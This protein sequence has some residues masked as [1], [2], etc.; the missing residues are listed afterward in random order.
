MGCGTSSAATSTGRSQGSQSSAVESPTPEAQ[1]EEYAV[2]IL[3][4]TPDLKAPLAAF[5]GSLPRYKSELACLAYLDSLEAV[6]EDLQRAITGKVAAVDPTSAAGPF[7]SALWGMVNKCLSE[8][9]GLNGPAAA[10]ELRQA[11]NSLR[12]ASEEVRQ[13]GQAYTV[14][15]APESA[16]YWERSCP[17]DPTAA[18][19]HIRAS[20]RIAVRMLAVFALKPFACSAQGRQ[21][22]AAL[23][24]S[25]YIEP[26]DAQPTR[27][28]RICPGDTL[29]DILDGIAES[30]ETTPGD[31]ERSKARWL[32]R[33]ISQVEDLPISVTVGDAG[34]LSACRRI[35]CACWLGC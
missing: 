5:L 10:L 30:R 8:Y 4:S 17:I 33:F 1:P 27:T 14:A 15:E 7:D 35:L 28:P 31:A 20:K 32:Q 26:A 24:R 22:A 9:K 34:I 11:E 16:P 23:R 29:A 19:H 2:T 13:L 3:L 18:F 12:L 6:R 21:Q 25:G